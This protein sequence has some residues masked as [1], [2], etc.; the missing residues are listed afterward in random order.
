MYD[1]ENVTKGYLKTHQTKTVNVCMHLNAFA[2]VDSE[3]CDE[4]SKFENLSESSKNNLSLIVD[5]L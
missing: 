2:Q 5:I 4:N 3:Y 1:N